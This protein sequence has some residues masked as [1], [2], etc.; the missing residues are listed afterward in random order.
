MHTPPPSPVTQRKFLR[1]RPSIACLLALSLLLASASA[2]SA[3]TNPPKQARRRGVHQKDQR[4][5]LRPAHSPPN[6][7]IISPPPTKVPTPLKFLGPMP[8]QPGE[9]YYTADINRYYEELA[10]DSPRA[11]FWK[12]A[13]QVRR[14]PRHGR[15]RHRQRRLPSRISINTRPIS[16]P[17]PTPARPPRNRPRRSSTP[18]NPST[19]SPAASTPLKPAARRCSSSSP[20]A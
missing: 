15:A 19:G 1:T 10:K 4:I 8:G 11:K 17:S 5:P 14:R 13:A 6:L 7:S 9:L 18:A 16:P 12:I 2:L 3:Q 20:I